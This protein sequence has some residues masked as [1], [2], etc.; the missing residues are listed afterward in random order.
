MKILLTILLISLSNNLLC[1]NADQLSTESFLSEFSA[2]ACKCIDSIYV[3]NKNQANISDEVSVCIKKQIATYQLSVKVLNNSVGKNDKSTTKKK[4]NLVVLN[5]NENSDEYKTYYY[6]IERYLMKNCEVLKSKISLNNVE[7]E[8][9]VS[10]NNEAMELYNQ[11]NVEAAKNNHTTAIDYYEKALKIDPK[12]AF[13]WDNLG[14]SYRKI[15]E[16]DKA[17]NAYQKSLEID[18]NGIT[19]LQNIAVVYQ[20]KKEFTK[21][22]DTYKKI[23]AI[24]KKNPEALYGIGLTYATGLG[25]L[26]K[27]LDYMCKAYSLY[28]EMKSPYRTDAE[29]IIAAIYAEM[30]GKGKEEEFMKILKDNNIEPKK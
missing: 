9:S 13:A 2:S 29:Q 11:G 8:N 23:A 10:A 5:T 17:L 21:A 19:P 4:D 22:I 14:I 12:F 16:Y 7:R 1:Q 30:K 28:I 6:E 26:E 27:G 24:D 25:E 3:A 15:G 18:S 20:F